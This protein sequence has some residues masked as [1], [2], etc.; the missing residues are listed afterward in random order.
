MI[1]VRELTRTPSGDLPIGEVAHIVAESS[2]GPRGKH[3]LKAHK[4]NEIENL[5]LLCPTHH[6]E[7][8]NAPKAWTVK[9]LKQLKERHERWGSE[10]LDRRPR[11]DCTTS[12]ATTEGIEINFEMATIRKDGYRGRPCYTFSVKNMAAEVIVHSIDAQVMALGVTPSKRL[13]ELRL[14]SMCLIPRTPVVFDFSSA[15]A[16]A[17]MPAAPP[18][19]NNLSAFLSASLKWTYDPLEAAIALQPGEVECFSAA[20]IP[21]DFA[22]GTLRLIASYWNIPLPLQ[23]VL[24]DSGLF[25]GTGSGVDVRS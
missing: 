7:I 21:G 18:D 25:L 11:S 10:T 8:D 24:C 14:A 12:G 22:L 5:V 1:R 4:R 13:S 15:Q 19:P 20:V 9:R 6:M 16:G 2:S 3:S 17:Q 23:G